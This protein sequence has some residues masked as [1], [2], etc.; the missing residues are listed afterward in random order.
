MHLKFVLSHN[1]LNY[2]TIKKR[3]ERIV[4]VSSLL[5]ELRTASGGTDVLLLCSF[6]LSTGPSQYPFN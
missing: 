2:V 5:L 4:R 6:R 1:G 3:L